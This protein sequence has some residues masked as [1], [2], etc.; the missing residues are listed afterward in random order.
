LRAGVNVV[1]PDSTFGGRTFEV[2]A[3]SLDQ[4][5]GE[6]RQPVT[7]VPPVLLDLSPGRFIWPLGVARRTF[8]VNV[9]HNTRDT[10]TAAIRMIVPDGWQ[11]D[12]AR[13]VHFT[14]EGEQRSLSFE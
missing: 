3:R 11:V 12:S 14:T 2:T 6:V 9:E 10:L 5:L 13:Q 8:T 1:F 4:G 7:V